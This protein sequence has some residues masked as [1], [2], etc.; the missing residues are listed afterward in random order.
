M[1]TIHP[2]RNKQLFLDDDAIESK[3]GLRRKL[4]EPERAGP[5]IRPDISRG[6]AGLQTASPP[7]W[8]PEKGVWEW[9]YTAAQRDIYAKNTIH[10]A[11][12]ADGLEWDIPNLGPL[13]VERLKGQ[14]CR[15][16]PRRHD[17]QEQPP[18]RP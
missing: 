12:S 2:G 16:R 11:T 17:A 1:K 9:W 8:N 13:R 3:Y 6:Q 18:R 14:Q 5:V 7:Q 4:N 10:Y 15:R